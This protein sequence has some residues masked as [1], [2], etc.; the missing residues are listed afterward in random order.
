MPHATHAINVIPGATIILD[1]GVDY[2]HRLPAPGEWKDPLFNCFRVLWPSFGC[3]L[4][5]CGV[6]HMAQI[7]HKTA[8]CE[9]RRIMTP[10]FVLLFVCYGAYGL[11]GQF[12]IAF[13]PV[14][15]A[16]ILQTLL[17]IHIVRVHNISRWN[18]LIEGFIGIL[19]CP[20]SFAQGMYTIRSVLLYNNNSIHTS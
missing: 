1:Q 20:C 9:F 15:F 7:G 8:M 16:I 4:C 6:W 13:V 17:R 10:F 2:Q 18:V 5:C 12:I 19:C 14:F 3:M 11:S